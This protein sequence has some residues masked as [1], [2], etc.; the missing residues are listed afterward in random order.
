MGD[1]L[2]PQPPPDA[3]RDDEN[4]RGDSAVD[5][6]YHQ[7]ANG[8]SARRASSSMLGRS[9]RKHTPAR[10]VTFKDDVDPSNG[11]ASGDD[12]S[13]APSSGRLRTSH[14][15][16]RSPSS[17]QP[18]SP[19]V[20]TPTGHGSQPT[21]LPRQPEHP[22]EPSRYDRAPHS[23]PTRPAASRPPPPPAVDAAASTSTGSLGVPPSATPVALAYTPPPPKTDSPDSPRGDNADGRALPSGHQPRP[24]PPAP[25]AAQAVDVAGES[26]EASAADQD[27]VRKYEQRVKLIEERQ[28]QVR[29]MREEQEAKLRQ[30]REQQKAKDE[31][32]RQRIHAEYE[33]S[34][35]ALAKEQPDVAHPLY[36]TNDRHAALLLHKLNAEIAQAERERAARD[37]Y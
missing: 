23:E 28:R 12:V 34:Q 21:E 32:D 15:P 2:I 31:A 35:D 17:S 27:V 25:T 22:R 33:E 36:L 26:D 4:L 14:S 20:R 18:T 10:E 9:P 8:A 5:D 7:E 1:D 6:D 3:A 29:Q 24:P 16:R 37:E 30:L 13:S 11:D 19:G